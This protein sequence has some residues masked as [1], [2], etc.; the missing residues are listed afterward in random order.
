MKKQLKVTNKFYFLGMHI[1]I[2]RLITYKIT[3]Q[4]LFIVENFNHLA[5]GKFERRPVENNWHIVTITY[6]EP[7]NQYI[8]ENAAGRKWSLYPTENENELRVGE[9]CPYYSHGYTIAEITNEEVYGVGREL[10][11]KLS[12]INV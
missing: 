4:Y 9:D 10:Y 12:D 2:P 11:W 8:W 7:N 3:Y 1:G 5:V 6:H